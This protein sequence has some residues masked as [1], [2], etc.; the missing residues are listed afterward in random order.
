MKTLN[1]AALSFLL[2]L[3]SREL[4]RVDRPVPLPPLSFLLSGGAAGRREDGVGGWL[5]LYIVLLGLDVGFAA[6]AA[7]VG[8][9]VV[10]TRLSLSPS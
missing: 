6:F 8:C 1:L 10:D 3:L 4:L 5:P 2:F 9:V 7:F